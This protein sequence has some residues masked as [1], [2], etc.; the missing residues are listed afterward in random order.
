[1]SGSETALV[2]IKAHITKAKE[3]KGRKI[4]ASPSALYR[5]IAEGLHK[6]VF[7]PVIDKMLRKTRMLNNEDG[8][9]Q[10]FDNTFSGGVDWPWY[11]KADA[12]EFY[13]KGCAR[14]FE[15]DLYRG[16]VRGGKG[17]GNAADKLARDDGGH[18]RL[19]H[20]KQHGNGLLINGS[21]YPS[22]LAVLRDGGH[23]ASQGG[24]T[25]SIKE[26]AYSVIMAGGVDP[27]GK[28]YPNE[29]NGDEVL[30]CGTDNTNLRADEPSQDTKAMIL[31]YSDGN[32]VRL[33]RS[34]NLGTRNKYAPERG[35]RYDGL[36]D[37]KG[38][39]KMDPDGDKRNRHRFRLVR[40]DGQDPIRFEGAARR[41][42]TQEVYEYEKDKKNRGR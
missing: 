33:F 42:T 11:I 2:R 32:P 29:D 25:A 34:Y 17:T 1:V 3:S 4:G 37:V 6:L 28:P 38:Y 13:N 26:G 12:E 8:L 24:I 7:L 14:V 27:K 23:G 22:Q 20:P 10:L 16:L 39:E 36:Y 31:N 18:F 5:D 21:W 15:T 19:M 30:Y 9:L 40:C 41:P 35:F